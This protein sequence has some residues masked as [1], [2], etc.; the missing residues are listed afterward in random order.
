MGRQAEDALRLFVADANAASATVDGERAAF[1]LRC[2]DDRGDPAR[3]SLIY[4]EL[5]GNPGVDIVLGPYT[6]E[7]VAV[8]APIAESRGKLLIN[9]AG[10]SDDL[11]Q[12]GYRMIV[13]LQTPASLCFAE[14]IRLLASLKFR[15]KRLAVVAPPTPCGDAV[16]RGIESAAEQRHIRRAGVRVRFRWNRAIDSEPARDELLA[17]IRRRRVNALVS[18]DSYARDVALMRAVVESGINVPV[19]ACSAAALQRFREDM[20][21]RAEGIV[22][23]SQWE[24]DSQAI[25]ELGPDPRD[26]ARRMKAETRTG[27]CDQI[28]A[29]AYAAGVLALEVLGRVGRCDQAAMREMFGKLRTGTLFGAFGIDPDTGRQLAHHMLTVQWHQG[30]KITIEPGPLTDRGVLEFP[31]GWRIIAAGVEMLRLTRRT[32]EDDEED[33]EPSD[34]D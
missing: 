22:A 15:R 17:M 8:A 1:A 16:S 27:E 20:G 18:A 24:P 2:H 19:L 9:H 7:L 34:R 10:E 5:C 30:R 3:C 28:A 25:P 26:F 32:S 33:E 21:D 13:G 6:S 29:Q 11:Y 14:F 12:R 31:S 4:Q 23:P